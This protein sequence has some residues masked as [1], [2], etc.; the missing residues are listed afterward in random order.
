VP[1]SRLDFQPDSGKQRTPALM[2]IAC[3]LLMAVIAGAAAAGWLR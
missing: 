2:A 1:A 3:G